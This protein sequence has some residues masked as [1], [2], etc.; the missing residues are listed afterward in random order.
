MNSEG[1]NPQTPVNLSNTLPHGYDAPCISKLNKK[2][3]SNRHK[4]KKNTHKMFKI[5]S[6]GIIETFIGYGA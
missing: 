2:Y 6:K 5:V 1:H 3:S 4:R